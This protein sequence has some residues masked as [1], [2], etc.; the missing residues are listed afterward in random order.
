MK[1]IISGCLT[2]I[3][4]LACFSGCMM[5]EPMDSTNNSS[6]NSSSS[7]SI[8]L[9]EPIQANLD[10]IDAYS[11][12]LSDEQKAE[13]NS[14][15]YQNTINTNATK[16]PIAVK[17][18]DPSVLYC[19]EDGYYYMY[20]TYDTPNK[21][22]YVN[23]AGIRCFRSKNLT[24]WET[25]G[26]ATFTISSEEV[27]FA[28]L[29][30]VEGVFEYSY[31]SHLMDETE[32]NDYLSSSWIKNGNIWAPCVIYDEDLDLYL[33]FSS[34]QTNPKETDV[35]PRYS[36]FLATSKTPYGPFIPWTGEIKAGTYANGQAYAQRYVNYSSYIYDFRGGITDNLGNTYAD[37]DAIDAEPFID[38]N[39]DKY[40]FFVSSRGASDMPT[41]NIYAMK[42]IDWYTPDY[43]TLT[44]IARPNYRTADDIVT[45]LSD[46]GEINEG[47]SVLYN[48]ENRKYYMTFSVN[49]HYKRTYSVK[50]AIADSPLGPYT[51]IDVKKGGKILGCD[52]EWIHR[53]GTGHHTFI[54]AGE[55][56][57]I[58]YPMH[59][60]RYINY[61]S[62]TNPSY[63]LRVIGVDRVYWTTNEDGL[64]VMASDGPSSDYRLRPQT[65]IEYTNVADRAT[66][67]CNQ[68]LEG[69]N[70][71]YLTDRHIR[72]LNNEPK[73]DF[74]AKKEPLVISL[75]FATPITLRGIMVAN[76]K[77]LNK[78]FDKISKIEVEYVVGNQPYIV[79]TGEVSFNWTEF[80]ASNKIN[81]DDEPTYIP[82][83]ASTAI[84]DE[85]S[86][87]RKIKIYLQ[88]QTAE[89]VTGLSVAEVTVIGK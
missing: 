59:N 8:E 1:K 79:S 6:S 34:G 88:N 9:L 71:K 83:C 41:N 21:G 45:L 63:K 57:F 39:G 40:L 17:T 77:E 67:S 56:K 53:A 43:S 37:I 66:V 50:Q 69:S 76:S 64:L 65:V 87:V 72:M 54:N 32:F 74:D 16:G 26:F 36:L 31:V 81:T 46:E 38:K 20:G 52:E 47:P 10:Y 30:P 24:D 82:G 13:V 68:T 80:Y 7:T 49:N 11:D 12:S 27:G 22:V 78:A 2:I 84:F 70:V 4:S 85:L 62:P 86:G 28:F 75:D 60:D 3:I 44:L 19:E 18:A 61:I 35:L 23:H 29:Q 89:T 51:K 42:M 14:L 73:Y 5:S 58:V 33:M 55:E 48:P 25:A 15:L